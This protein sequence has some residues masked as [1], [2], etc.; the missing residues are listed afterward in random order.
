MQRENPPPES[1]L[2]AGSRAP[3]SIVKVGGSLLSLPDLAARLREALTLLDGPAALIVG[4]G[5]A[6]D[7]VRDWGTV[8]D[9]DE[10]T[11]HWLAVDSLSLTARLVCDLLNRDGRDGGPAESVAEIVADWPGVC[12]A[13]SCGVIPVVNPR[14][15]LSSVADERSIE[16]PESW[17]VTS[18]SIAAAIAVHWNVSQFVLLKSVAKPAD[19]L[20]CDADASALTERPVDD[21]FAQLAPR[22][23]DV[24]WCNLRE[25]PV[26]CER[27]GPL[28]VADQAQRAVES[29]GSD[30]SATGADPN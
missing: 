5:A 22:L 26:R 18:D 29:G 11:A 8:F 27:W 6:V 2:A 9:L 16:L 21:W 25:T 12:R 13:I 7:T 10:V 4:G 3:C 24:L 20:L 30:A 15:L 17:A 23:A 19:G 1:T 14:G 28:G